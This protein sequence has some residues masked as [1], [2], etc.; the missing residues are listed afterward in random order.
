M[1]CLQTI[2]LSA[3]LGLLAMG[4]NNRP[5]YDGSKIDSFSGR[6]VKE[7]KPVSFSSGENV[8]LK[9]IHETAKSFGIPIGADGSFKIGWMPVGKYSAILIQQPKAG[10][11]GG[12]HMYNVPNGF[13]ILDG[14]TEYEVELGKDWNP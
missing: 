3:A 13:E 1:K 9:L 7:G 12:P 8:Q 11:R 5:T 14:K 4:C 10:E 2:L 6:L